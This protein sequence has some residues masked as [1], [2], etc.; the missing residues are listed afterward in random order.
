MAESDCSLEQT[1]DEQ[2]LCG[3]VS[4]A[5]SAAASVLTAGEPRGRAAVLM[6]AMVVVDRLPG[7]WLIRGRGCV[8]AFFPTP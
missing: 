5:G 3:V 8:K 6:A 4:S 7:A 2:V 1:S